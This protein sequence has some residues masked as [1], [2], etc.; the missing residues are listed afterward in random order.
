MG[1][2]DRE[3]LL[4]DL[5]LPGRYEVL[6]VLALG[7]PAETVALEEVGRHGDTGYWRD[8]DGVHHVP[9]RSLDEIIV[10]MAPG[11]G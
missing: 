4:R 7:M 10:G 11:D 9:K 5:D 8:A 3:G 6:L 1:S 2:V